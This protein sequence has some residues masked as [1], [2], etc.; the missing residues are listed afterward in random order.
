M[1]EPFGLQRPG[2]ETNSL[3]ARELQLTFSRGVAKI[4]STVAFV[5]A[6]G[7]EGHG[8]IYN[9]NREKM[10]FCDSPNCLRVRFQMG[11][12]LVA[13]TLEGIFFSC[14]FDVVDAVG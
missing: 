14:P 4:R 9:T 10:T 7:A 6:P 2:T 8:S 1:Q 11:R 12:R 13:L 3:R 5:V